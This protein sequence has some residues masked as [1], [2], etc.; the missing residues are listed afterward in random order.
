MRLTMNIIVELAI[1]IVASA[2]LLWLLLLILRSK[3][4]KR[5]VFVRLANFNIRNTALVTIGGLLPLFILLVGILNV[6]AYAEIASLLD[7]IGSSTALR[8]TKPWLKPGV[9]YIHDTVTINNKEIIHKLMDVLADAEYKRTSTHGRFGTMDYLTILLYRNK[10]DIGSFRIIGG[11]VLEIDKLISFHRYH[12]SDRELLRRVK[13]VLGFSTGY[14]EDD[15]S[16][17]ELITVPISEREVWVGT[18]QEWEA[19]QSA[20]NSLK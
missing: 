10:A 8:V 20:P 7:K 3:C 18:K 16:D 14:P 11:D 12:C 15:L 2:P 6:L 13:K 1:G 5:Q 4:R 19:R 17:G 9:G